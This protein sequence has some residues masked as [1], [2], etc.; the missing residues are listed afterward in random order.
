VT[1]LDSLG[2]EV[3]AISHNRWQ[4]DGAM[5]EEK[6]V[7]FSK[8][9][10]EGKPLWIEDARGNR[11]MEYITPPGAE[12]GYTP[13]YDIAGNVLAQYSMDGGGRWMVADAAGQPFHGW[14]AN[15]RAREDGSLV[16]EQ[17]RVH[18]TYDALRRPLEQRLH[19]D[20]GAALVV[21]RFV[22]GEAHPEAEARNLRG[23]AWRHDDPSGLVMQ[24]RFDFQ[25][26]LLEASRQLSRSH[27]ESV[28]D[29]A[30]ET[31]AEEVFS[32]RTSYDALGRMSRQENWHR[33]GQ[34]PAIYSPRYNQRG[35]LAGESL[36]VRGQETQAIR[37]ISYDAKG[38]RTRIAYGNGTATR[39]HYDPETFRLLQLRTTRNSPGERLPEPPSLLRN[40][41]VLQNLYYTYDPVGNISEILDDAYE[42]VFFNNQRV[43]P[44]NRY[45]YDALYRLIEA[46]GRENHQATDAPD[47]A[48]AEPYAVRFPISDQALRN[49]SQSYAYDAVGNILEIRHRADGGSWTRQS[50]YATNSNRLLRSWTGDGRRNAVDVRYDSHGSMLNLANTPEAYGLRWDYRDMIHRVNLGGGGQAF[51]SYDAG[52]QRSRK[53]IEHNGNRVEERLYLGGMEVY[54][55]WLNGSLVEEI[56]THHLFAGEQRLLIVEDVQLTDNP[57]LNAGLLHRYQYGNHLGSV[58]LELT[59]DEDPQVISYEEYHPYGTTAYRARNAALRAT[60]KRYRYTGMERD[61]ETGLSYHTARYY[62]PWLGRWGSV[63]PIGVAAGLNLWSYTNAKS[64]SFADTNGQC[65]ISSEPRLTSAFS[66]WSSAMRGLGRAGANL[67]MSLPS[68][69]GL[70]TGNPDTVISEDDYPEPEYQ[71]EQPNETI[72]RPG[73]PPP[74]P[75]ERPRS[76]QERVRRLRQVMQESY[77]RR[78]GLQRPD[79]RRPGI[80][81][82]EPIQPPPAWVG[83]GLPPLEELLNPEVIPP[84]PAWVAGLPPLDEL[85]NP[86]GRPPPNG[87][88]VAPPTTEELPETTTESEETITTTR[89]VTDESRRLEESEPDVGTR[90]SD[91]VPFYPMR[92]DGQVPIFIFPIFSPLPSFG[93][94]SWLLRLLGI[95]E[96]GSTS[97]ILLAPTMA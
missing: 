64:I 61:E 45:S 11:V 4:R 7:T 34:P 22:Y 76:L 27:R 69:V 90:A 55:R 93:L 57:N 44:R 13:C 1:H 59:G 66:A 43:E 85:L 42:P 71:Q 77:E 94:P 60:A 78:H 91:S 53:R 67:I 15:E 30:T 88:V 37:Q 16:L 24:Q 72:E 20:G 84:P 62:L 87:A 33:E 12:A 81:V 92:P 65:E 56:E 50:T 47:R 54:R 25:G 14:D 58:S 52:K 41:N 80:V 39:Y 10:A 3:V 40:A 36:T 70:A 17:R 35:V 51:Y 73:G 82:I 18:T 21:E 86:E 83:A 38:Q 97:P 79:I 95:S 46:S 89:P 32:Q 28:I 31:P 74:D 2:R 19:L 96:A 63:D 48:E 6:A 26:N 75:P 5:R 68:L 49:Y 23:Q 29:W 9:D 8:L